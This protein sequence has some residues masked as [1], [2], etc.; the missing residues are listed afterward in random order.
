MTTPREGKSLPSA[1][2]LNYDRLRT[3]GHL[4]KCGIK[5]IQIVSL[6]FALRKRALNSRF[7]GVVRGE[8]GDG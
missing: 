2:G 1:G 8:S 3:E 7:K 6:Y 5:S 4:G